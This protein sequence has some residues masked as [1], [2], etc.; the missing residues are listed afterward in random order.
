MS[1][2]GWGAAYPQAP[3]KGPGTH[4]PAPGGLG[5]KGPTMWMSV[6]YKSITSGSMEL[7]RV[8]RDTSDQRSP[9]GE[10]HDTGK[11]VLCNNH[12]FRPMLTYRWLT[13]HR[14]LF[15]VFMLQYLAQMGLAGAISIGWPNA[16]QIT[17][18]RCPKRYA[19]SE[20]ALR[21]E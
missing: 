20:Y 18:L 6:A 9:F 15:L 1:G 4:G 10:V 2:F 11:G 5:A 17:S 3:A 14:P 16:M 7:S 21:N 13:L 19:R 8:A 12:A